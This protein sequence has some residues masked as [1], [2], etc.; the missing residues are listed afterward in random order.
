MGSAA[1]SLLKDTL[2]LGVSVSGDRL[3][4]SSDL[5]RYG[6]NF[7]T[8]PVSSTGVV[9]QEIRIPSSSSTSASVLVGG[10]YRPNDVLS[11]GA[12]YIKAPSFTF[13]E[14]FLDSTGKQFSGTSPS[15]TAIAFPAVLS[16]HVPSRFGAGVAVR[17]P[18]A[19]SRLLLVFDVSRI[20][21]SDLAKDFVVTNSFSSVLPESFTVKDKTEIHAGGEYNLLTGKNPVFVRGGLFTSPDHRLQFAAT[22]ASPVTIAGTCDRTCAIATYTDQFNLLPQK[23]RVFGTIGGGIVLGP[24]LQLDASY[25]GT[26]EFVTSVAARF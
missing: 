13:S 15:G 9:I 26:K 1:V 20:K 23:T 10:Q 8:T 6:N 21:Y 24:H 18:Q 19:A 3:S 17:P 12:V 5:L 4:A 7:T 2:R 16:L 11:A 14:D 22:A 25:V